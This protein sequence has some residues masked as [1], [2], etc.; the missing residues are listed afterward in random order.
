MY[1]KK[2]FWESFISAMLKEI[3]GTK[4]SLNR[5]CLGDVCISALAIGEN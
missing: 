2:M 1:P 3:S 5:K 4:G